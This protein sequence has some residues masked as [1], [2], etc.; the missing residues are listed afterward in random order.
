MTRTND[1]IAQL[2][3][4]AAPKRPALKASHEVLR[5]LVIGLV[6]AIGA[7]LYLGLR[8]DLIERLTDVW[9]E[10]EIVSLLFLVLTS[11]MASVLVMTPDAYQKPA[12]LKLPYVVFAVL[13]MIIGGQIITIY[14]IQK[15]M[16]DINIHGM[17]CAI[18]IGA[19]AIVPSAI[20]FTILKKGASIRPLQAGAFAI[21]ITTGIGCLA[22]RLAEP[23]DSLIH[24]TQWHYLPTLAFALLGAMLGKWLLRW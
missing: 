11:I 20:M 2:A 15:M 23:N 21:F 8:P 24:L 3:Q 1:L 22:L 6:Y 7:Q 12:L 9:F 18:C 16:A 19:M 4:D 13:L 17:E 10:A 5:L 14:D